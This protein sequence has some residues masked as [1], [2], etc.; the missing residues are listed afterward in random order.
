M[1]GTAEGGR[2][3]AATNKLKHGDDF[4]KNIAAKA[5]EAWAENGRKPRGFAFNKE[6]AIT[7]GAK[8]GRISRRTKANNE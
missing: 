1:A 7:A 8:G 2:K 3:A 6:L 5:Q 4:Y